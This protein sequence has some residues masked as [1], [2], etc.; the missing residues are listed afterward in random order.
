MIPAAGSPGTSRCA[1]S[2]QAGLPDISRG[3]FKVPG[4]AGDCIGQVPVRHRGIAL[5]VGLLL[6]AAAAADS[7]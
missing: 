5:Q 2:Q 1:W 7:F 4:H 3:P 6:A